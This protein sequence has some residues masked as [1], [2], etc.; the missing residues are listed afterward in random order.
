ML[1]HVGRGNSIIPPP[2]NR[3]ARQVSRAF[4]FVE[5][6]TEAWG[7][8]KGRWGNTREIME[9][10]DARWVLQHLHPKILSEFR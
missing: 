4:I 1:C 2:P 9:S 6:E 3:A 7:V 8:W 10:W 5:E